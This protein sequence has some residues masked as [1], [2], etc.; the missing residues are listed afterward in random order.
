[1]RPDK[2]V[3]VAAARGPL[4]CYATGVPAW[5]PVC[6]G[7][8]CRSASCLRQWEAQYAPLVARSRGRTRFPRLAPLHRER[9]IKNA[10]PRTRVKQSHIGRNSHDQKGRWIR[11][12]IN[13]L[14]RCISLRV[15]H[16]WLRA[17]QA[18]APVEEPS[19]ATAATAPPGSKPNIVVIFG[20]DVGLTN[21][22]LP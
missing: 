22:S 15:L 14:E 7:R 21:V 1:M 12:P 18:A 11:P 16:G 8:N 4:D 5:P 9:L 3:I 10:W 19:A 17:A 13:S 6:G 20:D 2:F